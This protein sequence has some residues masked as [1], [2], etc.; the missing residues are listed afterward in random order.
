MKR[1][2][3][4]SAQFRAYLE[5]YYILLLSV[6]GSQSRLVQAYKAGVL[7]ERSGMIARIDSMFPD[8]ARQAYVFLLIMTYVWRKV[9][10]YLESLMSPL[11]GTVV[12]APSFTDIHDRLALGQILII[13][14][15]YATCKLRSFC[16]ASSVS[17][18]S[19]SYETSSTYK[20]SEVTLAR[21]IRISHRCTS[22]N[23][24]F[25]VM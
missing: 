15:K 25:W 14:N 8:E 24:R 2:P 12:P 11:P 19:H 5:A 17:P 20:R 7:D 23:V 9:N 6:L 10:R 22:T 16:L 18:R 1:S 13:S 21:R 3:R 4:T